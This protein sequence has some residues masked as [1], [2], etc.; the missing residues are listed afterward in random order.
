MKNGYE[1]IACPFCLANPDTQ[2]HSLI[3]TEVKS[4]IIVKGNYQDIFKETIPKEISETLMKIT[5]LRKDVL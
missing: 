4:K 2:M 5:E 3:C 1:S